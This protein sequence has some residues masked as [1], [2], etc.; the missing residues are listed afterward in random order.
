MRAY[1]SA[2]ALFLAASSA[3]AETRCGWLANPTP[4][5]WWLSDAQ[6]QWVIM[7]QGGPE[8]EG[9]ERIPDISARDYVRANGNHGYACACLTGAFSNGGV[10]RIDRVRQQALS[11]C[12]KDP[13]LP[14]P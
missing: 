4:G 9:M 11:A 3:V 7:A 13:A 12:R 2:L 6:G 14:R 10:T 5:N 1:L 8:P